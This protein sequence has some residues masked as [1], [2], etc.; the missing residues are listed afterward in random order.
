MHP[1]KTLALAPGR[2]G[3]G[4]KIRVAQ[5]P[6]SAD[7]SLEGEADHLIRATPLSPGGPAMSISRVPAKP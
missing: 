5:Q 7:R 2:D 3:R 4:T 1:W 6:A